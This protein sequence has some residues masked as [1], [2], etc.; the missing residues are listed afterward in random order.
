MK[1]HVI[2]AVLTASLT[3]SQAVA[4]QPP[5][6]PRPALVEQ[7]NARHGE[8]QTAFGLARGGQ[9]MELWSGPNG[10]WTLLATLPT[11]VSCIVAV[12]GQL[13][14]LPPPAAPADPA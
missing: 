9:V 1:S 7:L 14:L 5:C 11:G 12:G 2:A 13:Q 8:H 3:V 6:G 10:S 4:A